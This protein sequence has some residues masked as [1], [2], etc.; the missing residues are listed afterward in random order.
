[1]GKQKSRPK[2]VHDGEQPLKVKTRQQQTI[3]HTRGSPR[4]PKRLSP[5]PST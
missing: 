5:D 4:H 3:V 1:M 2:L